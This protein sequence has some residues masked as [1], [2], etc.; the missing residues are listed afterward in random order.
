MNPNWEQFTAQFFLIIFNIGCIEI[1]WD[2][3]R[4]H[5]K[6]YICI[7]DMIIEYNLNDKMLPI[8]FK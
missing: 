1:D 4:S 6:I 2:R 7:K 8:R 5:W 3:Q